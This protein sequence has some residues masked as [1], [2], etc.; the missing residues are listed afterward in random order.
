V[1]LLL[2]GGAWLLIV[3]F[4][5]GNV[6]LNQL[7]KE[8]PR[9]AAAE[10]SLNLYLMRAQSRY[11]LGTSEWGS[12]VNKHELYVQAQTTLNTGPVEQRLRFI[13]MAGELEGPEEALLQ[14]RELRKRLRANKI[15]PT[16]DQ[17]MLLSILRRL[18]TDY[19]RLRYD[20]PSVSDAEREQ[21]R[22]Q[23]DWYG[24]LALAPAGR[25]EAREE[26]LAAA[27]TA[28]A[29]R[30]QCATPDPEL[31]EEVLLPARR[32]ALMGALS[33]VGV[34]GSGLV[35]LALLV[36]L[37]LLIGR[38]KVQGGLT[39]GKSPAGVY[40]ETFALW[41]VL[42]I[43]LSF[44][45]ALLP[46]GSW[47]LMVAGLAMLLSLVAVLWARVRG[48]PFRQLRED[49][50]WTL[51]RQPVLEPA[52]GLGS[53]LMTMPI[54]IVGLVAMILLTFLQ[55]SVVGK[56]GGGPNDFFW[57]NNPSHPIAIELARG[58][59]GLRLQVFF[60]ASIVAPVV[61]ETMFRGVLYR[62]LRELSSWM[63][64]IGSILFST[65]LSCFIFAI[66]HPQGVLAVPAL[67][68]LACGFVLAREWRG[69]LLPGMVAHGLNNALVMVLGIVMLG[70]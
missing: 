46:L 34:L 22:Q 61:E 26:V 45:A 53:Y 59:W 65:L 68:A 70:D 13:V 36:T 27:G 67:M 60:L 1:A 57:P 18:Y 15:Q 6:V 44:G 16:K 19:S 48:I 40:V 33:V 14:L 31:R 39:T 50:G 51:G 32:T 20:L 47:R 64:T 29:A 5:V 56:S 21:L 8:T 62:H 24:D 52:A 49:I 10:G 43:G 4:V 35:G 42:F 11:L 37:L 23:L 58:N 7:A 66:I 28:V 3:A 55:T 12:G 17:Q 9:E 2:A 41:I 38:G 54:L 63:D 25:P 69:T 30:C